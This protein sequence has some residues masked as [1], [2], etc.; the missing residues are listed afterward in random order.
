MLCYVGKAT[1][2]FMVAMAVLLV[3]GLVLAFALIIHRAP[4]YRSI[5]DG[6]GATSP[7]NCDQGNLNNV[8]CSPARL[9]NL[10]VPAPPLVNQQPPRG[11]PGPV[12]PSK[13]NF[14]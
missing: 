12:L 13:P 2:I 5:Q 4:R 7:T 6:G 3:A 11:A 1:K 10:G 8:A 14:Q 9:P